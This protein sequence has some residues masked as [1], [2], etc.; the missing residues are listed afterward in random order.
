MSK[1]RDIAD[2]L[3]SPDFTGTV[4]ADG[5]QVDGAAGD[6]ATFTGAGTSP[7]V[8]ANLVFN[9]VYDVNARVVSAREG[10]NLASRLSLETGRDNTG[11]TVEALRVGSNG[12][13]SF[14]EDTGT[15]PKFFWDAS[16]ESLGIGNSSPTTALDVTGTITADGLTVALPS[17]AGETLF[18]GGSQSDRGLKV[19]VSN[20]DGF[21]NSAWAINA[22]A[23]N[24]GSTLTLKTRNSDSLKLDANGDISFYEDTG[25]T[26]KFFWDASAE[27]LGI[28]TSTPATALDVTGTI[29]AD[30]LTVANS[31][32]G[33]VYVSRNSGASV[34]LQAQA[35]IGKIGTSS[36]HKLGI[37]TNGS[38]RLTVDTNGKVGIGNLAPATALDVTGTVTATA[39]AGDGSALTNL[40]SG[41][42]GGG[43]G[44]WTVISSQTVSSAVA[45]L[46]FL[47]SVSSTYSHYVIKF[48]S[49]LC[50]S[51]AY[52]NLQV[53]LSANGGTTWH[54]Q[55]NSL[56]D[57]TSASSPA[58]TN[59]GVATLGQ[60][61]GS[62]APSSGVA[63]FFGLSSAVKKSYFSTGVTQYDVSHGKARVASSVGSTSLS[64][65]SYMAVVDSL[66]VRIV[67]ANLTA[68]TF[69]L[70]GIKNT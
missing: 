23:P 33:N 70:Y 42:G 7:D 44:A 35:A 37:I 48:E 25:T 53:D 12:D 55:W 67:T 61:V 58:F 15:T 11:A 45:S 64:S 41:G 51:D 9:P 65:S 6:I 18:Y 21:D 3:V 20:S 16:A 4:T 57:R 52:N 36:N 56:I 13:V 60:Y 40:P 28:G 22:T 29:T 1:A 46:E 19:S 38:T 59:S 50:S 62:M 2:V 34:H 54:S 63:H 27:S 8:E 43:G 69:T 39:F 49:V 24:S 10:S 17:N 68:G 30:A 47:N 5:L 26:P 31:G 14:Y 66:K 32:N